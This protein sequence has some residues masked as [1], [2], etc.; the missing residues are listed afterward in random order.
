MKSNPQKDKSDFKKFPTS[1]VIRF[2]GTR[3]PYGEEEEIQK[4][5][6]KNNIIS[7]NQLLQKFPGIV[8][9]KL[10]TALSPADIVNLVDETQKINS[11]YTPPDF[12]S[13]FIIE[14]PY[15]TNTGK[16][17]STLLSN[18]NVEDAYIESDPVPPATCNFTGTNPDIINQGYL[19]PAP[20]GI[21]A[22][23]AWNINGGCGNGGVKLIDIELGWNLDHEDIV[24][25]GVSL[26]WGNEN[27]DFKYHG[28]AVLGIILMQDNNKGGLGITPK[29][30]NANV[31]AQLSDSGHNVINDAIMEAI[32][33]LDA[34]DILLLEAQFTERN[35][36]RKHWPVEVKSMTFDVIELATAR[37]IIVIEAAG[38]GSLFENRGNN[39]DEFTNRNNKKVLD[40][41]SDDFK[42]SGA[43]MVAAA[44]NSDAH[45][46]ILSSNYGNRINCFAWGADVYTAGELST[47]YVPDFNGTSS[48]SAII[49]GAAIAIQSIVEAAGKPRLTPAQMRDVLSNDSTGTP[50]RNRI[51]VMPDLKKIIQGL[52]S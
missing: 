28:T 22:K 48:A 43:I 33:N 14:C 2:K 6:K 31:I 32:D 12:L 50:S 51:G 52:L 46:R 11:K 21:N 1:I 16:L 7:W 30:N 25:S 3:V 8:M 38:N 42:E 49:A 23:F 44:S 13:C 29:I 10:F 36:P 4:Y 47:E 19:N 18:K 27:P 26:L 9:R 37:G 24:G 35:S 5:L 17:L 40:R 15:G 20:E 45:G 34:G 39:L 41:T